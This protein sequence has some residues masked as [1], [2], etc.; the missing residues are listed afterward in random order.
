[1]GDRG[2]LVNGL[3]KVGHSVVVAPTN[4]ALQRWARVRFSPFAVPRQAIGRKSR[5]RILHEQHTGVQDRWA[6]RNG[7]SHSRL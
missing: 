6:R 2:L 5:R 3:Y 4:G 1:M 7:R